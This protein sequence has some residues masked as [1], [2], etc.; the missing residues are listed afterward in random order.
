MR[1]TT[2]HRIRGKRGGAPPVGIETLHALDDDGPIVRTLFPVR[3]RRL[4]SGTVVPGLRV[5]DG[6]ELEQDEAIGGRAFECLERTINRQR[7]EMGVAR[8]L[9]IHP[10][11]GIHCGLIA[12]RFF[13]DENHIS[14]HRAL[15]SN[16]GASVCHTHPACE[17]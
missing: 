11:V 2:R 16:G 14:G 3:N 12:D 10:A 9:A 7:L 8:C 1:C 5:F 4:V 15:Q 6:G 13:A 17:S